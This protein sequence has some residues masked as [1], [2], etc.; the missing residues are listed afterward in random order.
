MILIVDDEPVFRTLVTEALRRE[1]HELIVCSAASEALER[2]EEHDPDL[3]IS[4]IVM[5]GMDGFA[6]RKEY[7]ERFPRRNTPF[8][9]LS[10]QSAPEQIVKGLDADVDDY[11]TK[12]IVPEVLRAKVR[13]LL[14]RCARHTSKTFTGNLALFPFI[15]IIRFCEQHGLTGE[16]DFETD[17]WAITVPF[18]AGEMLIDTIEDGDAVLER[19]Y[20]ME[21]GRFT[22]RT[23]TVDFSSLESVG[24]DSGS[25]TTESQPAPGLPMGR[26][27]GIKAGKRLF[28]IQTELATHPELQ[29]I[30]VVI[31]DGNT[32]LK[33]ATKP[34]VD[35]DRNRL[36][37]LIEDQ[38]RG[39]ETEIRTKIESLGQEKNRSDDQEFFHLLDEGFLAYRNGEFQQALEVWSKAREIKP[40]DPTLKVNLK[41]VRLKIDQ[42]AS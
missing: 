6:F 4:D 42:G 13:S 11:L 7:S 5:P 3:I 23:G 22:I 2:L 20:D 33:R 8:V 41:I 24:V 27:S 31:L 29:V 15:K 21:R 37:A 1:G 16:V 25:R 38:H 39:I 40:D 17:D 19:L 18:R 26:L 35:A 28:Q 32:V 14:A 9:F 34:P 30:T 12:P 36:E 10:S